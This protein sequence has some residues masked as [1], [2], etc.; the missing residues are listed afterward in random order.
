MSRKEEIVDVAR[1]LLERDGP[2]G[3]TMQAIADRLG[4]RSPS[5]YKHVANRHEVEVALLARGFREQASAFC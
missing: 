5:L 2:E 3:V 1:D 4:I